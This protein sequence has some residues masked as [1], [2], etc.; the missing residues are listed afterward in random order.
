MS[1]FPQHIHIHNHGNA[2]Q[3]FGSYPLEND[4]VT[5]AAHDYEPDPELGEIVKQRP[6]ITYNNTRTTKSGRKAPD[7]IEIRFGNARPVEAVRKVMRDHGFSFSEKQTLWYAH[8]NALSRELANQWQEEDVDVDTTQYTKHNFWAKVQD[9]GQFSDLRDRTE[10]MVTGVPPQFFYNKG[11]L[12]KAYPSLFNL[13]QRGGLFFKKFFNKPVEDE[14]DPSQSYDGALVAEKMKDLADGMEKEIDAKINSATSRQRPTRKRIQVAKGMRDEGLILRETQISLYALSH[15]HLS[16]K[17]EEFTFLKNIR[18]KSHVALIRL[19]A[20]AILQNWKTESIQS[21][22]ENDKIT[23]QKLGI[24][25][26]EEWSSASSQLVELSKEFSN[27][28]KENN[29]KKDIQ[30]KEMEMEAFK[31]DIPGFHPTPPTLLSRVIK[32]A[33]IEL[34]HTI[35]DPEA[36]KG[37]ILDAISA[38]YTDHAPALFAVEINSTLRKILNLKGYNLIGDDFLKFQSSEKFDRIIMNPPFENSQDIDH[39]N[40]A[41][42][43]LRPGGRLV[44]IISAGSL[45]RQFKKDVAFREMLSQK[46]AYIS[47]RIEGAFA[48]S[49][50]PANINVHIIAINQDS[51][52]I[53]SEDNA[54][55]VTPSSDPIPN[56]EPDD[57]ELLELEAEAELEL[58][59]MRVE[60]ERMRKPRPLQGGAGVNLEKLHHLR[61]SAWG[62]QQNSAVLDFK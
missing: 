53:P 10:F 22:L 23:F 46:K 61:Q 4:I 29:F 35:L 7:G 40:H 43:L 39:V 6:L 37:D 50:I 48:N 3:Y 1:S 18:T 51:T 16:G 55:P 52:P 9:Q 20:R 44:A 58:L 38:Y 56:N 15:A 42:K 13:F 25:S 62:F 59:K 24:S 17:I 5:E 49:F 12:L 8:D 36:G 30:I 31:E 60:M 41:L 26:I 14:H 2:N 54:F 45:F 21:V 33:N 32:L 57:I 34:H 11:H 27:T 47:E 19:Y 28:T